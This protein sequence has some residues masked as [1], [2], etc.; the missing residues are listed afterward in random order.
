MTSFSTTSLMIQC[1]NTDRYSVCVCVCIASVQQL[2]KTKDI[3]FSEKNIAKNVYDFGLKRD[4]NI[5]NSP[6][7]INSI[8]IIHSMIPMTQPVN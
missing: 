5:F 2:N 1:L 3:F 4:A 6:K 7:K 8:S